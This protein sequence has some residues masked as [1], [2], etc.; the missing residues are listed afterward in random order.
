MM[1]ID[2]RYLLWR[3][4]PRRVVE[5]G[6]LNNNTVLDNAEFMAAY[7][8]LISE[9]KIMVSLRDMYNLYEQVLRCKKLQ[10]DMAE[11][12]VFRGGSAK[13]ISMF[14]GN[15]RLHLFDTFGG[16]PATD[17]KI[18]WHTP[19]D[20]AATTLEEVQ[21][22]L[23]DYPGI[24]YHKGLFPDSVDTATASG[25]FSFVH[26]DADIY[27]STLDGLDFFYPR[28]TDGGVLIA[29]DY[30]SRTCPGVKAAFDA[31]CRTKNVKAFPVWDTQC[32]IVKGPVEDVFTA[33]ISAR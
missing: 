7:A 15:A 17:G 29:H 32:L 28:L 30:S 18:D 6:L 24:E 19:G 14:K 33:Q 9:A 21:A 5:T 27:Q 20:F 3:K 16:M 31:F 12:G 23:K 8:K 26:L 22:Y 1:I 11:V 2:W 13:L 25:I 10:G 4:W